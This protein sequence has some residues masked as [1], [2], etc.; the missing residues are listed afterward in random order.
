ML[1][2]KGKFGTAKVMLDTFS[3]DG[4]KTVSQ[5]YEFLNHPVFTNPISIMP[6][7]HVGKGAVIGFTMKLT[8]KVIPNVIGV[9]I[10]CG[11]LSADM[12]NTLLYKI[13]PEELDSK[14]R[15]K[16]PFDTNV[17][18]NK[19]YI[20]DSFYNSVNIATEQF[21]QQFNK[22]FNTDY[23]KITNI[24]ENWIK[25]KCKEVDMDYERVVNSLGTLGGGNHFVE[26]GVDNEDKFWITIHSGS[27]QFGLKIAN[28]HQRKAGKGVLSY[29]EGPD[30]FE[31]LIDMVIAQKYAEY[32]RET[33]LSEIIDITKIN[34]SCKITST[35]NY[36]DFNDF[37]IR[38]GAIS[39]YENKQ[40]IIPLNM[41]D[42]ILICEG[43]SNEEWNYSAPHGA[44]RVDS[45]K[46]AKENLNLDEA[47]KRM[48]E[49]GIYFSTL[50]L[51]ETKQAY[52]DSKIIENGIDPTAK[53]INKIKPIIS[54]KG[55]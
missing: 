54:C 22:N 53:I 4:E 5:I 17:H 20:P 39:S 50:P 52:K 12:D 55:H 43:K 51:D 9:D 6:D 38:K 16:V 44:G 18:K 28:F 21:R 19:K 25:A 47:K 33:M 34:P 7:C 11:M 41:E 15:E 30:M 32:N 10:G 31:Y 13:K 48:T 35:H 3:G 8:D 2:Y 46:W 14:I 1:E 27:R 37:I 23:K 24:D 26:V 49:K 40:M 36:I 45:R 29:L 42:G